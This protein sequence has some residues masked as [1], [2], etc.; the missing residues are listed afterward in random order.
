MQTQ[1]V[2]KHNVAVWDE[3]Y[4]R[5]LGRVTLRAEEINHFDCCG[6]VAAKIAL[7]QSEIDRLGIDR[8][9]YVYIRRAN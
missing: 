3:N 4:A 9:D 6:S 1:S 8:D 5:E 7:P 2:K